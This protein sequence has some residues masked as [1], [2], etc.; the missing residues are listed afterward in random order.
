L[1]GEGRLPAGRQGV[2]VAIRFPCPL[3]PLPPGEGRGFG[4]FSG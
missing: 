4:L 1:M 2:R 3:P